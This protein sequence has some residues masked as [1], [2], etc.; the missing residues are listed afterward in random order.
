[1]CGLQLVPP[2]VRVLHSAAEGLDEAHQHAARG[3]DEALAT[4]VV[5]VELPPRCGPLAV[6]V[7]LGE[8]G[9]EL[10]LLERDVDAARR[11]LVEDLLARARILGVLVRV[12]LLGSAL[13]EVLP[14][15]DG[16]N[17]VLLALAELLPQH[18]G[19]VVGAAELVPTELPRRRQTLRA[20]LC[21]QPLQQLCRACVLQC[22]RPVL[23]IWH[24][25]AAAHVQ[26]LQR[27]E[28]VGLV[29]LL[30]DVANLALHLLNGHGGSGGHSVRVLEVY[31]LFQSVL[32]RNEKIFQF[33]FYEC[34]Q[35]HS[36]LTV[37]IQLQM[38][39]TD[40]VV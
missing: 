40:Q 23:L 29:Q 14:V 28:E 37:Q 33:Y 25:V 12:G 36:S 6:G 8:D 32:V 21:R 39:T 31:E 27:A 38:L 11:L 2:L 17:L 15:D 26:L 24:S 18:T 22:P 19:D 1:M 16:I 20:L 13:G 34:V 9:R 30:Q 5:E 4:V 10:V 3:V 7:V 35:A